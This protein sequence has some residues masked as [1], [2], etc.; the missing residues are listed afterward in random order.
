MK[1]P[2]KSTKQA[3]INIEEYYAVKVKSL[4]RGFKLE[5]ATFKWL[6]FYIFLE[7]VRPASLY[8]VIDIL[9]W[10]QI[11]LLFAAYTAISDRSIKWVK[12]P[13]TPLVFIFS[14]IVLL[15]CVFACLSR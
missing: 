6:C 9:P 11:T 14:L 1:L 10:T 5:N 7:Y 12:S 3:E 13:A 8:P 15:S 2:G 4:W